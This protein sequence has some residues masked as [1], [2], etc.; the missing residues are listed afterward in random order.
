[1]LLQNSNQNAD[2]KKINKFNISQEFQEFLMEI[3][4]KFPVSQDFCNPGKLDSLL[5]RLPVSRS[6]KTRDF[7]IQNCICKFPGN[8][9][10]FQWKY[11]LFSIFLNLDNLKI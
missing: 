7:F 1:M 2:Q 3:G 8:F 6:G 5:E 11:T 4:W 10:K 9:S